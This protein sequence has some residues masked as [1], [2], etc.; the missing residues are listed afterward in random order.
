MS[1]SRVINQNVVVV[2]GGTAGWMTALAM[3]HFFSGTGLR[4]RLIESEDVGIVG[5]GEATIPPIVDYHKMIG[6]DENEFLSACQATFKLGIEFVNWSAPGSRYIH[7]FGQY[8]QPLDGLPFHHHW[9]RYRDLKRKEGN[10]YHP[11]DDFSLAARAAYGGKFMRPIEAPNTPLE[12]IR[13]AFHFDEHLYGRFL[14][15]IAE[16]KGVERIEGKIINVLCDGETG[17]IRT[18]QLDDGRDVGGDFFIDCSGFRS[19]LLGETLKTPFQDWSHWL[20]CDSAVAIPCASAGPPDSHTRATAHS[21]GW[22]WH[23]PLQ[24][25]VGNGHVFSSAFMDMEEATRILLSN[26]DGEPL[27]EPRLLK[28]KAGRREQFWRGNCVAIGLA[29]GFLEPLE[30]TSIHLTQAAIMRLIALMPRGRPDPSS[31]VLFNRLTAEEYDRIR[32]FIILHYH[33]TQRDDSDF[34]NHV[35][36]MP[37][38]D[39]L[40]E[41]ISLY[42]ETGRIISAHEELFGEANWLAVLEG[43][44][45]AATNW[46]P[47]ADRMTDLELVERLGRVENVV[48]RCLDYMPGHQEFIDTQCVVPQT[49]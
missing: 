36:T 9:L 17:D 37:I 45:V 21:A 22:Q 29:S 30:S 14:R 2:G 42:R 40:A 34:W 46:H 23:I 48:G 6:I 15:Q 18:L 16:K 44:G 26:L 12:Q 11:L 5:V 47:A 4:V 7:P 39:S 33:Q 35:R 49:R 43:Q 31:A 27:A 24:H 10:A 3:A 20:P 38:P 1:E 32:D 19:L 41:R 25:R 8:G 13:Y 28:F